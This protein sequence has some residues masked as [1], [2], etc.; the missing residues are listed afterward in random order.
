MSNIAHAHLEQFRPC[1]ADD[2][3]I[4]L[5]DHSEF[6]RGI[7]FSDSR[8]HLL[9]QSPA[10]PRFTLA[11]QCHRPRLFDRQPNTNGGIANQQFLV[12]GPVRRLRV[13]GGQRAFPSPVAHRRYE[14]GCT[15]SEGGV[16]G[17]EV[18]S[19]WSGC[20]IVDENGLP[21]L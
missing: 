17:S 16:T 21:C 10:G 15:D 4:A 20:Y 11:E 1:A 19:S 13:S 12:R 6:P 7:T 18:A 2:I 5:I 3:A 9:S 8:Y 14:D